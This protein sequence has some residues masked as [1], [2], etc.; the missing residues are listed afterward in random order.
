[1]KKILVIEDNLDIRENIAEILELANYTV[2]TAE[3]GNE[4]VETALSI[5]PD[6]VVCDI[7][8]PELDGYEVLNIMHHNSDLQNTPFIFLSAKTENSEFRK[9][10]QLGADDYIPKPFDTSHLLNA[11]EKRLKKQNV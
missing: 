1:M 10:I 5:Y 3:N 8:M 7:M 4:G 6:L 11:V 2:Y 9:G